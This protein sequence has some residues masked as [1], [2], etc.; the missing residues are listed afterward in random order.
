VHAYNNLGCVYLK[1]GEFDKA[2]S[3]FE[4]AIEINPTFYIKAGENLRKARVA[5]NQLSLDQLTTI[6]KDLHN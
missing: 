2:I 6:F 4:K 5:K 1:Q 3:C